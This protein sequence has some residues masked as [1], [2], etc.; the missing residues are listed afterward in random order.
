MTSVI[1]IAPVQHDD[2]HDLSIMVGE[3]LNEI[4]AKIHLKAF[5]FNR[6]ETKL[7][8]KDLIAKSKYWVFVAKDT[9]TGESIGFVSLYE[10]YALYSEGAY[11]TMPELYVKPEWRSKS[12]GQKLLEKVNDFAQEKGW[13]RIEVTTPPLPE[14]ERTLT[15]Y[16]DNGFEITGGRKLKAD[17]NA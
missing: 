11:G 6:E 7:Q 16:Q 12:V 2:Y 8:A 3:L 9:E 14:F 15:F 4:M 17:I 13:H 5:N 1:Q 10:S